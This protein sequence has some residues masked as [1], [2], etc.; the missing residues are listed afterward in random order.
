MKAFAN[1]GE[2]GLPGTDVEARPAVGFEGF[3]GGA[4]FGDLCL[5]VILTFGCW[6]I[7][8]AAENF[9]I[10]EVVI[11]EFLVALEPAEFVGEGEISHGD[12]AGE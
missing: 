6:K 5:G 4:K 7:G 8:E 11:G 12:E 9:A 10:G 3:D 2:V 1:A